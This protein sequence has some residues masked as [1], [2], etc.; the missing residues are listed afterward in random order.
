VHAERPVTPPAWE[1]LDGTLHVDD[2][3]QPWMVFCHEWVQ[4]ADGAMCAMRLSADLRAPAGDPVDLFR[5]SDA[6]W[7]CPIGEGKNA[8]V[9]DGPF[10]MRPGDG[11]L[12]MLWASIG[13]TG[14]AQGVARSP[15]GD[16]RGPWQQ[17]GEPLYAEDGG[18]GMVFRTFNG[19]LM[20]ALHAP[21]G[22]KEERPVFI[23]LVL[24][25]GQL[26]RA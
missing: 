11:S 19:D 2:A 12:L 8:Y 14:Y 3:A 16:I 15:S 7:A 13:R 6:P 23:P 4:I 18:H 10:V 26:K 1:C 25:D 9:T 21:N 22:P 24:T 5:A 20:M 17:V